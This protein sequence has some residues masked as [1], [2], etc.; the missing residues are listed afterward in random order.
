MNQVDHNDFWM[1]TDNPVSKAGVFPYLGS[2]ISSDLIPDKVYNVLRSEEEL[3]RADVVDSIKLLPL[4][5]GHAM[6]GTDAGM[7]K[8]EDKGIHGVVGENVYLKNGILYADIKVFSE[9][10]KEQILNGKKELS[11]GF[12]CDYDITPGIYNGQPYDVIQK[13]L[14][15]NH[16]ALVEEGRMGH[17]ICIEAPEVLQDGDEVRQEEVVVDDLENQEDKEDKED[18]LPD[19]KE[20]SDNENVQIGVD[21]FWNINEKDEAFEEYLKET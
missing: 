2:Q 18:K 12:F 1:I 14:R 10:L 15:G 21:F 17:D 4:V 9:H 3:G 20:L 5:D 11:M 16:L 8:P 19:L 6:L 13:N 7:I